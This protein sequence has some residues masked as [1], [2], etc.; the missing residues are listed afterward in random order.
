ME[1]DVLRWS[2]AEIADVVRRREVDP[3]AVVRASLEHIAALDPMLNAFQ[4]VR[5][6]AVEAEARALAKR[7]DLPHLPL[8]G[9]PVAIKDDVD[10]AGAPPCL[11]TGARCG[12]AAHVDAPSVARLRDAGALLV[13]KTRLPELLLWGFTESASFGATRN[14]WVLDRTPGG[15]SG[16]SAVAV[17]AG[18]VPVALGSDGFGSIR[19][20]AACC[21]VLGLKPGPGVVPQRERGERAWFGMS[22]WGPLATTVRDASLLLDVLAGRSPVDVEPVTRPLRVAVSAKPPSPGIPVA[23]QFERVLDDV[24]EVLARVGHEVRQA[25]PPYRVND[26]TAIYQR[27]TQAAAKEAE[28]SRWRLLERRTRGG[29]R[30][31]RLWRRVAKPTD[32]QANAALAHTTNWFGDHDVLMVPTLAQPAPLLNAYDG[33]GYVQTLAR[34]TFFAPFAGYWNLPGL[35][36]MSVPAGVRDGLPIGVQFVAPRGGERLLLAVAAQLE[37]LRPWARHAPIA[38]PPTV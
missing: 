13:G 15:S 2:A 19:I 8:A 18:M 25:H 12:S 28:A 37:Q 21:G 20:P 33:L 32:R 26:I 10:I 30:I 16:G 22:E 24:A 11:G 29:A 38:A 3:S 31:G 6:D 17:A 35:P 1:S 14:P 4:F 5:A 9:V 23:P 27:H 7:R 34:Q 36:A